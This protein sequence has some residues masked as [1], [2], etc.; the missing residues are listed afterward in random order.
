MS[1]VDRRIETKLIIDHAFKQFK[2]NIE[3]LLEYRDMHANVQSKWMVYHTNHTI[4]YLV[5][6]IPNEQL[7]SG[8]QYYLLY[9]LLI[10]VRGINI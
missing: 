7:T 8:V 5:L 10:N 9:L 3:C 2:F 1:V 6:I 4:Y